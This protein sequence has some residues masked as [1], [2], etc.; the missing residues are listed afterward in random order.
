MLLIFLAGCIVSET[1]DPIP[2]PAYGKALAENWCS[3]CHRVSPEQDPTIDSEAPAFML[4]AATRNDAFLREFMSEQHF[5][6]PTFRLR[7]QQKADILAYI[8]QLRGAE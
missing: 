1:Q 2:D 4:V 8:E 5:P 3:D 6:M 7:D